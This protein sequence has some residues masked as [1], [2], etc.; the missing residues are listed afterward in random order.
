MISNLRHH[1]DWVWGMLNSAKAA[2][3]HHTQVSSSTGNQ[4]PMV[5]P[6][7]Q[8]LCVANTSLILLNQ[9]YHLGILTVTV[10]LLADTDASFSCGL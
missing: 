6:C 2:Q 10:P 8:F 5:D 7:P 3:I 1:L 9:F 4:S